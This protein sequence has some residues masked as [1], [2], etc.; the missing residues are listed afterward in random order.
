MNPARHLTSPSIGR[1]SQYNWMRSYADVPRSLDATPMSTSPRRPPPER[2]SSPQPRPRFHAARLL[3]YAVFL[4]G[5]THIL[6]IAFVWD[7][8]GQRLSCALHCISI[9][10]RPSP[11]TLRPDQHRSRSHAWRTTESITA[12]HQAAARALPTLHRVASPSVAFAARAIRFPIEPR[13]SFFPTASVVVAH[14]R[15]LPFSIFCALIG[16]EH[17]ITSGVP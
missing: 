8:S 10:G 2:C 16:G 1:L 17:L 9:V 5:V 3:L 4:T 15:C 11:L 12:L 13:P 14:A 7:I 6:A